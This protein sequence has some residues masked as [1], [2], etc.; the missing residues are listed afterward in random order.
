MFATVTLPL[1]WPGV[2]AGM[3]LGFAKA[4]GEFGATITFV[5]AIPGQTRTVPAAI[6]GYTQTPGGEAGA[7]RLSFVAVAIALI[8]VVASEVLTRRLA[9]SGRLP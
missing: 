4:L 9:G 6:Y 3:I 8:A 7:L 1:A 2:L 5:A